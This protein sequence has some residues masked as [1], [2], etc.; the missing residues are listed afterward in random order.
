[1]KNDKSAITENARKAMPR[2]GRGF[3]A[4]WEVKQEMLRPLIVNLLT[5]AIL[6]LAA[7]G[8][9]DRVVSLFS[10]PQKVDDW[11][12]FCVLEPH[13]TKPGEH[14]PVIA[15]L[16]IINVRTTPYSAS[17]LAVLAKVRSSEDRM[18]IDP[19]IAIS[20]KD[21]LKGESI[22]DIQ[23]DSEFN[24][25]KGSAAPEQLSKT[26]WKVNVA[27]IKPGVILKFTI[28]TTVDRAISSRASIE[29]LPI[30][31]SY[32]RSP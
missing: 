31:L 13:A 8:L 12:L 24:K 3:F 27:N 23:E 15:D 32:A 19:F 25:E 10:S 22:T 30:H 1:L 21:Y 14:G 9:R 17:E 29:T 16:F 7:V 11:P 5:A 20:L 6:F 28:F 2:H 26:R 18:E 4:G